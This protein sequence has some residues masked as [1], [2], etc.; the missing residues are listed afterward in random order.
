MKRTLLVIGLCCSLAGLRAQ[1]ECDSIFA[2]FQHWEAQLEKLNY[3]DPELINLHYLFLQDVKRDIRRFQQN[4]LPVMHQCLYLDYYAAKAAYQKVLYKT[5]RAEEILSAKKNHVDQIFYH[6]AEEELA[7]RDTSNALYNLDRALQ[8]NKYQPEALLLKARLKLA[9]KSYQESVDLIHLLYTQTELDEEME[10][11][12]S[13]FTIELY[14]KLY[15]VGDALVK[16]NHSAEALEVFLALEQFC[17]NMPSGYCND[18]YYRG[19]LRSR[20]GVYES[21]LSIAREAEKRRNYEM[22]RKFYQYAEEYRKKG[23]VTE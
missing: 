19:I 22:A 13:D 14:E 23:E 5:D 20:E 2:T 21:Y 6:R 3:E 15:S 4:T 1:T 17:T 18:D 16:S 8:F 7:F 12:V 10:M 11:A 9:Q